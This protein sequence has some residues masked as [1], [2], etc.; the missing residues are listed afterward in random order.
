MRRVRKRDPIYGTW[1]RIR[2]WCGYIKGAPEVQRK[3]YEGIRICDDW[4]SFRT[5]ECWCLGHGYGNG[6]SLVRIDKAGDYCPENCIFTTR[7]KA[8]GMRRCVRRM[9][10]GRSI[11]D[12]IG[13]A[14]I[15]LDQAYANRVAN[16]VFVQGYDLKTALDPR[17]AFRDG[18]ILPTVRCR[19]CG[20]EFSPF[21]RVQVYC[22]RKC[23]DEAYNESRRVPECCN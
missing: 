13:D 19:R 5:F 12:V 16:R 10:D 21:T 22:S 17:I 2:R 3:V 23:R 20:K 14:E 7:Q 6:L 8:N 11:R 4:L 18:N 1:I 9:P 15:G